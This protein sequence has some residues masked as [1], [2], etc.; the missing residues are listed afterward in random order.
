MKASSE[1]QTRWICQLILQLATDNHLKILAKPANQIATSPFEHLKG[2]HGKS[3]DEKL[4]DL[5][6]AKE[7]FGSIDSYISTIKGVRVIRSKKHITYK[8]KS[9]PV[10]KMAIKGKTLNVYLALK[11][12]EYA[13]SKYIFTDVSNVK[14]YTNYPMRVRASSAR[15]VKWIKE[16]VSHIIQKG[17][18][19]N[20]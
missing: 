9:L 3:F 8:V 4:C 10:A 13:E 16:L 19:G 12:N 1:R 11:P 20:D 2:R 6:V 15:Q 5:P 18:T 14:K 17:G 7:R